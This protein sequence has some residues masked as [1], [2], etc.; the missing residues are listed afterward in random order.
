MAFPPPTLVEM[1]LVQDLSTVA[2]RTRRP[3]CW[4]SLWQPPVWTEKFPLADKTPVTPKSLLFFGARRNRSSSQARMTG[5]GD[6]LPG[7]SFSSDAVGAGEELL[8]TQLD[9]SP[10]SASIGWGLLLWP[11][12]R[13]DRRQEYHWR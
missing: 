4:I 13:S 11:C 8:A 3:I 10:P 9:A 5:Q 6:W 12:R 2:K 1:R 7:P